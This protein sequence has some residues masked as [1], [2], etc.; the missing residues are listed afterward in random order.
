M[1]SEQAVTIRRGPPPLECR[2]NIASKNDTFEGG[3][4]AGSEIRR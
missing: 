1:N 3:S 4:V 2:Y